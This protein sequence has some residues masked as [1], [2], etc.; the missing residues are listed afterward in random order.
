MIG[1]TLPLFEKGLLVLIVNLSLY[2][3]NFVHRNTTS[4][5][6]VIVIDFVGQVVFRFCIINKSGLNIDVLI[7][8][9]VV[10]VALEHY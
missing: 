8:I 10:H 5:L 1:I 7:S 3:L 9:R 6:I 4:G 2:S